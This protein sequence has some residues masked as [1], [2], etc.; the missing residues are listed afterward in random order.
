MRCLA[1]CPHCY[2][3]WW[4]NAVWPVRTLVRERRAQQ[5]AS[6]DHTHPTCSCTKR[7]GTPLGGC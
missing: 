4:H 2:T 7:K 1:V 6:A 5:C 3:A